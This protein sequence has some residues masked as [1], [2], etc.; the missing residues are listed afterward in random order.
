MINLW[1]QNPW[2]RRAVF[3]VPHVVVCLVIMDIVMSPIQALFADLDAQIVEQQA[4]L[5]RF[6]AFI[7]QDGSIQALERQRGGLEQYEEFLKG[8]NEGAIAAD[9]Q[10]RLKA[11]VDRA[12]CKLRSV[13][14]LPTKLEDQMRYI[15]ARIEMNGSLQAIQKALYAIETGKPYLFVTGAVLKPSTPI[16]G[17]DAVLEPTIEALLEILGAEP[18][19]G[20]KQ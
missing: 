6:N 5:A 8:Q 3:L 20:L 17:T 4:L 2:A 13:Q 14:S 16:G 12:G 10:T 7:A 18:T 15:G 9:L 11:I 1:R 19:E